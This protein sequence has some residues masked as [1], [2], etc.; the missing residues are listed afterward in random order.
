[1]NS[2]NTFNQNGGT[3][4]C[5]ARDCHSFVDSCNFINKA[6]SQSPKVEIHTRPKLCHFGR[7]VMRAKL[8]CLKCFVPVTALE[9]SYGKIFI[10][11]TEISVTGPAW[12]LIWTHR[13][14][15]KEKSGEARSRKP[16][17]PG[18]PGSYEE[19]LMDILKYSS[20][21]KCAFIWFLNCQLTLRMKKHQQCHQR[22]IIILFVAG[23]QFLTRNRR[24][25]G[26]RRHLRSGANAAKFT[27]NVREKSWFWCSI[28]WGR[29]T[30]YNFY[31]LQ[32]KNTS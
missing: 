17:Q 28:T 21:T 12:P 14:F 32:T 30:F 6:I 25:H 26:R 3:K 20:A 8:F 16:S 1:M 11:V 5:I 18:W 7:Y 9:C 27:V 2:R 15:Y 24:F 10:P 23:S 13:Y 19:A 22:S 31:E 4:T 29:L